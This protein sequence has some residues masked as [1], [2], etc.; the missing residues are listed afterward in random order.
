MAWTVSARKTAFRDDRQS[1]QLFY[2]VKNHGV[3]RKRVK[4]GG[5]QGHRRETQVLR[6]ADEK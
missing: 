5:T 6:H 2:L 1:Y 3:E 4:G